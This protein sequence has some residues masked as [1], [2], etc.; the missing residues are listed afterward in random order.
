MPRERRHLEHGSKVIAMTKR[1]KQE[2]RPPR[3]RRH[4]S[5]DNRRWWDEASG[6]WFPLTEE[7]DTLEIQLEDAGGTSAVAS[8]LSTL[9]SQLGNAY[10]RFVGRAHSA[11]PRWPTYAILGKTFPAPRAFLATLPP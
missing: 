7:R 4:Y 5:K 8:L 6:R 1:S 3:G 11:D 2:M 10:Y 9:G